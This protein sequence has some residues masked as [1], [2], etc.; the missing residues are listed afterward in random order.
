M[1]RPFLSESLRFLLFAALVPLIAGCGGAPYDALINKRLSA[2]RSGAPFRMLS[3]PAEIPD[4]PIKLRIPIAY[5]NSYTPESGHPDDKGR[6]RPDR[7][8]PPFLTLPGLRICYEGTVND[9]TGRLPFY[10]YVAAVEGGD[11][12]AISKDLLAK[13]KE[14]FKD[15]PDAWENVDAR[16]PRDRAVPWKKVRVV[17]DQMFRPGGEDSEPRPLPGIFELWIHDAEK[18]VVIL[19]WRTPTAIEGKSSTPPGATN[20]LIQ[21]SLEPK[22]DFSSLPALTA[23]TLEIEAPAADA[24][25]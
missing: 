22:P 1:P 16:S 14:T 24:A 3:A 11:S 20:P 18:Y 5:R 10:C 13:L 2:L 4:T 7:L 12:T 9:S 17:G 23:G 21:V 19:G 25:K 15:A 8:Q 6:I